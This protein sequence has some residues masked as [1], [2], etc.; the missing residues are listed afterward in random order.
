M[1]ESPRIPPDARRRLPV[2]R[3]PRRRRVA[4]N[5]AE[6]E[7]GLRRAREQALDLV[8]LPEMWPTSFPTTFGISDGDRGRVLAE[9]DSALAA[10]AELS[11][12]LALAV[13]GSAF[14]PPDAPGAKPTN[15]LHLF[16]QGERVLAYDKVHLFSPTA[17]PLTFAAGRAPPPTVATRLA[18]V[19]G[20]VCYD[21]RFPELW[22]RPFLEGAELLVVPAQWPDTRAAHWRALVIGL[23][24]SNQCFVVACNRT[25]RDAL[26][27][28]A[29]ELVFPGNS[30]VVDPAGTV[31]AEGR[32]EP[33]LVAAS[34]DLAL[35][36]ELRRQVPLERDR[37][38][39]LYAGW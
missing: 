4:A 27:Q 11:R 14:A 3:P 7:L 29:L 25:G 30:L 28:R 18:R 20:G 24:V 32:G 6:V 34:C 10:L 13:A 35:V 38:P 5:L 37:R 33:G 19:S 1:V 31:L 9:S 23:A 22:R 17:E 39:E 26:G 2:R 21:L 12:S 8:V 16:E 15:R 36:R